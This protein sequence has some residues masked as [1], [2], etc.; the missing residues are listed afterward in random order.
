M[1]AEYLRVAEV[2]GRVSVNNND[3]FGNTNN[4]GNSIS[5]R[6]LGKQGYKIFA[7]NIINCISTFSL[8]K[9]S[10]GQYLKCYLHFKSQLKFQKK[11]FMIQDLIFRASVGF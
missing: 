9:T 6:K 1:F 7:L 3:P 2:I 8:V 10:F 5:Y 4:E 11:L